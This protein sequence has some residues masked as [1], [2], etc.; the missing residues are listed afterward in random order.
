MYFKLDIVNVY[1]YYICS[2]TK[3]IY[4]KKLLFPNLISDTELF[5]AQFTL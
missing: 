4:D 2:I 5:T 3:Y 1:I